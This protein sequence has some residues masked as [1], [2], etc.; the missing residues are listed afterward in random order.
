MAS[1]RKHRAAILEDSGPFPDGLGLAYFHSYDNHPERADNTCGQ[2]VIASILDYLNLVPFAI[3]RTELSHHDNELHYDSRALLDFIIHEHGPNWPVM[4]SG[5]TLRKTI[6]RALG[7][8]SVKF[9]EIVKPPLTP[10]KVPHERLI[11]FLSSGKGP[12]II[13]LDAHKLGWG[14]RFSL[15]W[16]IAIGYNSEHVRIASW[17][18][19]YRIPW[20]LFM[21][22]WRCWFLTYPY[23]YYQI[24]IAKRD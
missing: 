8:Y 1:K 23:N 15:H 18:K 20:D 4:N 5:V 21:K 24:Q 3:E 6:T 19:T 11:R 12:V 10:R 7:C 22:A 17:G 14:P 2:A 13:L 9:E 16:A